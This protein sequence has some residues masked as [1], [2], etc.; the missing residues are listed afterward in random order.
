MIV[1]T[2]PTAS[3]KTARAVHLARAIGGEIVSADSRQVYRSMDIGSGKDLDEYGEV[4]YHMIDVA[5]AGEVFNL[6]RYLD[7]ARAAIASIE[8]RGKTPIVCGGSGMYVEALARGTILPRVPRNDDLRQRLDP[9]P[10]DELRSILASMK[11]LHNTSDTDTRARAIRAI[12]IQTYYRDHPEADTGRPSG[13]LVRPLIIGVDID[14]NTRRERI[15]RRLDQR[16]AAGMVDEV[17][18]LIDSGVDPDILI[19]YGLEYRFI[20][21]HLL[22]A[23][24]AAEM[25]RQLETAIHQFAKRQMTWLRGM[26]RRGLPICWISA[27]LPP[28]EFTDSIIS[29]MA[30]RQ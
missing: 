8:S 13:P 3:G 16:L 6:F 1:I 15:S 22:G 17:R 26:E 28:R 19:G 4:P 10:L 20:T 30:A 24:S 11:T 23:L 18:A 14:R 9:L 21:R 29:L 25:R 5:P 2:G 7:E 27:S 12:E